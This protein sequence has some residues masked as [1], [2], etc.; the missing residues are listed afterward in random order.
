MRHELM[1]KVDAFTSATQSQL[2]MQ[3]AFCVAGICLTT[4]NRLAAHN[5]DLNLILKSNCNYDFY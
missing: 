5:T 4:N 1:S 3:P 2:K